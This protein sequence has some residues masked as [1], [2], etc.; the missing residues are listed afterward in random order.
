MFRLL[1][2]LA[3]LAA[4]AVACNKTQCMDLCDDKMPCDPPFQCL[5]SHCLVWDIDAGQPPACPK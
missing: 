3:V 5:Q 2:A 1:L 4:G